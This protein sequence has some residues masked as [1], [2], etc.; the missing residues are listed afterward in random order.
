MICKACGGMDFQSVEIAFTSPDL[1]APS[2][3]EM[4]FCVDCGTA[5]V[6]ERTREKAFWNREDGR[7]RRKEHRLQRMCFMCEKNCVCDPECERYQ[8][9]KMMLQEEE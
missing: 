9:A 3:H 7:K 1:Y 2:K 6:S 4:L 8:G 5:R